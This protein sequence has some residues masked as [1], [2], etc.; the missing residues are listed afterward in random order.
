[1]RLLLHENQLTLSITKREHEKLQVGL[2]TLHS[3]LI[4]VL[5]QDMLTVYINHQKEM[6]VI[7]Y[8]QKEYDKKHKLSKLEWNE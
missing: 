5:F 6:A 3:G 4:K 8:I 1:M 7:D 2:N